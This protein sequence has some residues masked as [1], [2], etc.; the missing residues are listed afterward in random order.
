MRQVAAKAL[1][2]LLSLRYAEIDKTIS[3]GKPIK[4]A[5]LGCPTSS[6]PKICIL[7]DGANSRIWLFVPMV[8]SVPDRE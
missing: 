8:G 2:S 3:I 6:R 7:C 1:K 4:D 5:A